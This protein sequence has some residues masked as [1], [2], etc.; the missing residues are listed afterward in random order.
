MNK[1]HTFIH[2]CHGVN[3]AVT[4]RADESWHSSPAWSPCFQGRL[5]AGPPPS[6]ESCVDHCVRN[7]YARARFMVNPCFPSVSLEF[8]NMPLTECLSNH[9]TIK[10]LGAESL[11]SFLGWLHS[12]RDVT[13]CWRKW[14]HPVWLQWEWTHSSVP[15]GC[16]GPSPAR[17][18]LCWFCFLF[19]H[20]NRF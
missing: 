9:P 4:P 14:A 6:T 1:E 20:C 17:L 19:F 7:S 2:F 8:W 5:L 18:S 15:L 13:T 3:L 16:L 11:T 10:S 12:T